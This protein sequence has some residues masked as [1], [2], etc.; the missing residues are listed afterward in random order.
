MSE[1][2]TPP[3]QPAEPDEPLT[4]WRGV[5]LEVGQRVIYNPTRIFDIYEGFI[6]SLERN[7]R[8]AIQV[9]VLRRN[10]ANASYTVVDPILWAMPHRVTVVH[11]LPPSTHPTDDEMRAAGTHIAAERRRA[12]SG[13]RNPRRHR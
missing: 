3:G 4:D 13:R 1:E 8:G 9:R 10:N 2:N 12:Q 5:V 7:W 6:Y 11:G